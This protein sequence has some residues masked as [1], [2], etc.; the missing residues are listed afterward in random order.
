MAPTEPVIPDPY[1]F[2]T[3][4]SID[5]G[6][7]C[8]GTCSV[9]CDESGPEC[10]FCRPE[11][12]PPPTLPPEKIVDDIATI[13]EDSSGGTDGTGGGEGSSAI[14][15]FN[16]NNYLIGGFGTATVTIGLLLFAAML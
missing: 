3:C 4:V 9:G 2:D 6:G 14:K 12:T 15:I 10:E 8:N 16:Y 7:N 1:I 5:C 11:F 13:G